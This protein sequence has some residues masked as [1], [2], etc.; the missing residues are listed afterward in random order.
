MEEHRKNPACAACHSQMDPLG[1]GLENF[2]AIGAWRTQDGKFPVDA[3]G[4]LPDGRTFQTPAQLKA[5]LK[6]DREVF[7]RAMTEKLLI[8]ALGRGLERYDRPAVNADH[9]QAAGAG[10]PVF[11]D[12]LGIVNSLPFQMR[13]ARACRRDRFRAMGESIE[14]NFITGKHIS[15]RTLLRGMGAAIALPALDAMFPALAAPAKPRRAA[16]RWCTCRT[17]SS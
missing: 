12:G 13:S 5:I 10:L 8:Y 15:R 11:T 3:S 2:N 7:V 4:A 17:A 6:Q 1:F 9:R 16:W 14:M